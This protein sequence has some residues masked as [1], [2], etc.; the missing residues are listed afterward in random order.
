MAMRKTKAALSTALA[1]TL[2][3]GMTPVAQAD[4]EGV[5][6]EGAAVVAAQDDAAAQA[7][8]QEAAS[9]DATAEEA[10]VE[11]AAVEEAADAEAGEGSTAEARDVDALVEGAAL[12]AGAVEVEAGTVTVTAEARAANVDA[13]LASTRAS[14]LVTGLSDEFKY[15][16]KYESNRNYDQ[17]F[18]SGDEYHAM[19]YYQFD[20]RYTL[21]AFVQYCYAYDS[22]TF[23]M[24][25]FAND[26]SVD[27]ASSDMYDYAQGKLTPLGQQ[28][29]DAWHAAYQANPGLF[30][31]LQDTYAYDNMYMP[32]ENYL[33]SRGVDISGR[34]DC[35]RGM[36]WG[37]YNLFGAGGWRRF[38]GG[39]FGGVYYEGC[40]LS[41]DMSD[42]E[43]VVTLAQ[44]V[45]DKNGEF[46]PSSPYIW[47]YQNR[48]TNEMEECLGYLPDLVNG[49]WY[50][51]AVNYVKAN[52]LMSGYSG[53]PL[54]GRFG[55]EDRITRAQIAAVLYRYVTGGASDGYYAGLDRFDDV[56]DGSWY[57]AAI[58]WA[59]QAGIVN[60]YGSSFGPDDYAT[61]EQVAT[62]IARTA[63]YFG[64]D[65][66][67]HTGNIWSFPDASSM[68][69]YAVDGMAWCND[70]GII[71]GSSNSDGS[72]TLSPQRSCTRS[73]FAKMVM[74]LTRDVL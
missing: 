15:F 48:Y 20:N 6:A 42:V 13:T 16:A 3:F 11:S 68:A 27:F 32:A 29:E 63:Q 44:Y 49:A 31:N 45:I 26:P 72:L 5:A 7:A 37:L 34:A 23:A 9:A 55:P 41:N 17:G 52:G 51:E 24:F 70:H 59:A 38:V 54:D 57:E 39:T 10:A 46:L 1:V 47:S 61:R 64:W 36:C 2:V 67:S 71:S 33:A 28:I 73:Q 58:N 53:Y 14:G 21:Q 4:E 74:V 60:G 35:V 18:S 40:G 12:D 22:A 66:T 65:I 25:A 56:A 62:I 69:S 30:A 50:M 43:F 8:G 19:G